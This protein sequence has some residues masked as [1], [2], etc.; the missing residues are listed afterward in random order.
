MAKTLKLALVGCGAIADWHEQAIR[1]VPE[2]E[3]SAAIDVDA[4]KLER[5][6]EYGVDL[7]INP[8]EIDGRALK[9]QVRSFGKEH[10]LPR[11]RWR[12]F[13]CSGSTAGQT[14]AFSLL[15]HGAYLAV[16]GFTREPV[17]V[18]ISNLMALDAKCEGN[19]GCLPEYY[20]AVLELVRDGSVKIEP[21][22]REF[23]MD[24][25]NEVLAAAR[26]HSLDRRPVLVP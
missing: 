1:E 25:V 10:G 17:N 13:E 9:Q 11:T 18:R 2:V 20:P 16:V 26:S 7:A 14:T 4:A 15:N 23:A 6:Q 12:I 8:A 21:F 19:W 5:M 22:V 24:E 3:I